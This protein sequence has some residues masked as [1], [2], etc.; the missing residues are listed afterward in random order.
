MS[1]GQKLVRGQAGTML[2]VR[3]LDRR[4]ENGRVLYPVIDP[5][6]KVVTA[7]VTTPEGEE[8]TI[9]MEPS[10]HATLTAANGYAQYKAPAGFEGERD[11]TLWLHPIV[12]VGTDVFPGLERVA[13]QVESVG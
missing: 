2:Y 5:T 11:G 12:T 3:L 1:Y 6:G 4:V 10:A 8:S 7:E 13:I 9:T